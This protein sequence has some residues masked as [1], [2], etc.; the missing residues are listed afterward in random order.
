MDPKNSAFGHLND[1]LQKRLQGRRIAMLC[2]DGVEEVELTSPRDALVEHGAHVEVVS[3]KKAP[4]QAW[5][6]DKP[7][8]SYDVDHTLDDVSCDDYDGLVLPGGV[9]NP[10]NLR[11]DE[12]AVAFVRDFVQAGKP[13]AAICHGPWTLLEAGGV[14]G[15][16]MTSWPSLMTDLR[17][18]GALWA[19]SEVIRDGA[20]VTSR[21][22]DDLPAF[23][24]E[25]IE[26]I[27]TVQ[28]SPAL[29]AAFDSKRAAAKSAVAPSAH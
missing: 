25:M 14:K 10:D 24:K 16:K 4:I 29:S 17:N 9:M 1:Q 15:K 18:A 8:K 21:K 6:H 23:N 13:I 7:S 20:L 19:D 26:M 22:P 27:A 2:T 11:T 12:N 5:N 3:L 28:P